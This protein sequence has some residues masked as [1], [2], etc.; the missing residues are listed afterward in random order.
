MRKLENLRKEALRSTT[1]RGHK[2]ERFDRTYRH[3]WYSKCIVCK[4]SVQIDDEPGPNGIDISGT[5]I[6]MHCPV[7]RIDKIIVEVRGGVA[8]CDDERVEIIDYDNH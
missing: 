7:E 8:Y 1:F 6:A 5:A 2:M 3:W 4:A